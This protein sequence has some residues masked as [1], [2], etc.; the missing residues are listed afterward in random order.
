MRFNIYW[1]SNSATTSPFLTRP[2][3]FGSSSNTIMKSPSRPMEPPP[4]GGPPPPRIEPPTK[5]PAVDPR[6]ESDDE[7][8]LDV[9]FLV[10]LLDAE[11]VAARSEKRLPDP[12][13]APR[14]EAADRPADADPESEPSD[15]D[16]LLALFEDV[17]VMVDA[18]G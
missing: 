15:W 8:L 17:M 7:L 12:L 2:P 6:L 10:E 9:A 14:L 3:G 13:A 1:R 4:P 18:P 5:P 11:L 16:P